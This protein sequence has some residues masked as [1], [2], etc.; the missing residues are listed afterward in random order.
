MILTQDNEPVTH[1]TPAIAREPII[2]CQ[3]VS[4]VIDQDLGLCPVRKRKVQKFNDSNIEK[5]MFHSRKLLV[6]VYSE[7]ITNCIF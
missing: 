3:S 7:N 2:N 1:S 5:R 6:K 4:P